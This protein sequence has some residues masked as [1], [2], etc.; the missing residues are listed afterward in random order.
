MSSDLQTPMGTGIV[1]F[2]D[3]QEA[4]EFALEMNGKVYTLDEIRA[5]VHMDEHGANPQILPI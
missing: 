5:K 1:A 2:L 3:K 4:E